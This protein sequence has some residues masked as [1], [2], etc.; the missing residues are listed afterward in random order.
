MYVGRFAAPDGDYFGHVQEKNTRG[1]KH[2][3]LIVW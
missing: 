1:L 2:T 3:C